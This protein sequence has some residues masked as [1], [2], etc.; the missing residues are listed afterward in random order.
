MSELLIPRANAFIPDCPLPARR[1]KKNPEE[2]VASNKICV[3]LIRPVL[4]GAGD[5]AKHDGLQS[6][7]L[8][9]QE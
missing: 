5:Q 7:I 6:S 4:V 8:V 1:K 9:V 3:K 2:P